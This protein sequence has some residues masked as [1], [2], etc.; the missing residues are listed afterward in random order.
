MYQPVCTR[1]SYHAPLGSLM[2][3][4]HNPLR[5]TGAETQPGPSAPGASG[6]TTTPQPAAAAGE[7]VV[8]GADGAAASVPARLT[9]AVRAFVHDPF[10]ASNPDERALV[11]GI[12][13]AGLWLWVVAVSFA[14]LFTIVLVLY[15][16][17]A[18]LQLIFRPQ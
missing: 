10:P 7:G 15:G 6:G 2:V 8:P 1:E 9:R 17:W 12:R 14:A 3:F 16:V 5:G 13:T 4:S 11:Y 18:L